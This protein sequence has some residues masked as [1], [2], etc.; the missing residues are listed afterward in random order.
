MDG[1]RLDSLDGLRGL[2]ALAIVVL[3]A[4]LYTTHDSGDLSAPGDAILHE[5]RLGLVLFFVLSG[6]LLYRPWLSP[7]PQGRP[8]VARV[9]RYA[10]RRAARILPGYYLA[11]AGSLAIVL[12]AGDQGHLPPAHL[13]PLFLVF[14]QNFS[15]ATVGKIDPPMWTLAIEASFYVVLPLFALAARGLGRGRAAH[16]LLPLWVLLAGIAYNAILADVH[17]PASALAMSLPAMLPYFA[18][19][20]LAAALLPRRPIGRGAVA[21]LVLTGLAA[22]AADGWWHVTTFSVEGRVFRDL[23]AAVG[24]GTIVLA[25]ASAARPGPLA[26][27]PLRS[28]GEVSYGLY[29]W[30]LPLIVALRA[31]HLWPAATVPA[32]AVLLPVSLAVATASWRWVERPVVRAAKRFEAAPRDRR[33][34]LAAA[35]STR[36]G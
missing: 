32:L 28:L 30:H 24:F 12:L 21:A 25:A 14:G 3:H 1:G 15:A 5:L 31:L 8:F 6:F 17:L 18:C 22:V 10:V 11:L 36:A 35:L 34:P 7:D 26:S 33:P 27:R 20:M 2:A 23:P 29:L 4:W 16:V 13:L 9:R 19:G